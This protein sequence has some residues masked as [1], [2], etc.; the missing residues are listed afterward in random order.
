[1]SPRP[2][3]KKFK[4]SYKSESN[5]LFKMSN[6][7]AHHYHL[8][9]NYFLIVNEFCGQVLIHYRKYRVEADWMAPTKEGITL[10]PLTW[11]E[12]VDSMPLQNFHY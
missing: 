8:G 10:Q 7:P 9:D 6:I 5:G 2:P 1:M 3:A 11:Q 12:F 4:M